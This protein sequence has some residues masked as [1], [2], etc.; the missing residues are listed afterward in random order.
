MI[1]PLVSVIVPCYN[2]AE[3]LPE[4]LESVLNQSWQNWECIIVN[5]GSQD[6]TALIADDW[7]KRDRRFRL[8][9]QDNQGVS[10]ARNTG[11]L[12]S[13]GDFIQF[14]DGDDI[15]SN[16]KFKLSLDLANSDEECILV[17]SDFKM[18]TN[19]L[20]NE[21]EPYCKLIPS[22]FNYESFLK[23]WDIDFTIPIHCGFFK[24][25]LLQGFEFN[26]NLQGRE[27]WFLW[28][29]VIKNATKCLYIDEP[30]AFY[31]RHNSGATKN[32]QLMHENFIKA[33]RYIYNTLDDEGKQII[34][35]K[36]LDV[37]EKESFKNVQLLRMGLDSKD[38]IEIERGRIAWGFIGSFIFRLLRKTGHQLL[39]GNKIN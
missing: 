25:K 20:K 28:L 29:Y 17:I 3:F 13:K 35:S 14:L 18:F 9:N 16:D 24:S 34:F 27:D 23:K 37:Y 12:S 22:D 21:S 1:N 36:V 2:Q 30:L 33:N 39:K 7:C 26:E 4:T 10:A 32:F 19:S 11:I 38:F 6:N 31:R 5:D 8:I 15:I